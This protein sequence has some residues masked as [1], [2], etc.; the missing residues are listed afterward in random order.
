MKFLPT[1]GYSMMFKFSSLCKES[2]YNSNS[3]LEFLE[4]G[5]PT[6]PSQSEY[7]VL[8]THANCLT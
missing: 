3:Y 1:L 4:S 6:F 7:M 8:H 2:Q 5:K